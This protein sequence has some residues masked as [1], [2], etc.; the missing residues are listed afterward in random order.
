MP[1]S[2]GA[3]NSPRTPRLHHT[4]PAAFVRIRTFLA[5]VDQRFADVLNTGHLLQSMAETDLDVLPVTGRRACCRGL[6]SAR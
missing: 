5:G 1:V 3:M 6:L 2:G 4:R